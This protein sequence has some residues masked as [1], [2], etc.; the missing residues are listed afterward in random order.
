[1]TDPLEPQLLRRLEPWNRAARRLVAR[2]TSDAAA[3]A[4]RA[5]AKT[6]ATAAPRAAVRTPAYRRGSDRLDD[7]QADVLKLI[8][9]AR[10]AFYVDA[11]DLLRPGLDPDHHRVDAGP[12]KAGAAIARGAVLQGYTL[13]AELAGPFGEASRTLASATALAA[14]KD[15]DDRWIES[16]EDRTARALTRAILTAL[17][18]SQI[19]LL[20]AVLA[21]LE[22]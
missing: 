1:M 21:A 2:G 16:W 11:F 20:T 8:R 19:A 13:E 9:S 12:T 10:E 22:K 4:S 7:L 18:D 6:S 5:V 15:G 17:S 3:H 14:R